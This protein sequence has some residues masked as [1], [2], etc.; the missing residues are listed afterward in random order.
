MCIRDRTGTDDAGNVGSFSGA[1]PLTSAS[2]SS[3]KAFA[4]LTEANVLDWI[5]A[6]VVDDYEVHVNAQI[7]K[8][9]DEIVTPVTEKDM[10]WA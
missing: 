7:Q 2:V 9:I 1:T 10:P 8:Q 5:K 6:I 3:F 4:D